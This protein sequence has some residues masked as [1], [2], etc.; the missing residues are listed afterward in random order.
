MVLSFQFH[1]FR[2]YLYLDINV[3]IPR[4]KNTESNI[5]GPVKT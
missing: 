2:A 1:I 3:A 5:L 4:E